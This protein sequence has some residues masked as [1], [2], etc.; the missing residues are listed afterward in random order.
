M[1]TQRGD[2]FA[3]LR[4]I[5]ERTTHFSFPNLP[6]PPIPPNKPA[7]EE[8]V[9]WG[10]HVYCFSWIR[11]FN[12]LVNGII[13]L[14]DAGNTPSAIIVARSVFELGAHA[15]YV[16]KHLKQ[17][18]DSKNL[19]AA[20]KFLGPIKTGSRYINEQHP[21][22]SE[23]FPEPVHIRKAVNCLGEMLPEAA[24]EDYS[25][26]SEY[27]HPNMLAFSQYYRW[28]NPFEVQFVDH[29]ARG[30]FGSTTS[31]CLLGLM[32]IQ[33]ILRLTQEKTALFC[34]IE[35]LEDIVNSTG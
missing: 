14:R 1:D 34:L 11:H 21:E 22:E 29:E 5:A 23:M 18:I 26:L 25:F 20:W 28:P 13:T 10:A 9:N 32:A 19:D 3:T 2:P 12:T 33:E 24:T 15:Y 35:L 30:V 7:T 16:K 4:V 8:L 27:C 31:A 17:H 6:R